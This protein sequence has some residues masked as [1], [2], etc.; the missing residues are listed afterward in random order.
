MDQ[1]PI[2]FMGTEDYPG[3]ERRLRWLINNFNVVQN[4]YGD[5]NPLEMRRLMDDVSRDLADRIVSEVGGS[6]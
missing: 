2:N 1:G 5:Q 3:P 6:P 4:F